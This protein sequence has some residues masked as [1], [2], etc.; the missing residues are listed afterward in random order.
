MLVTLINSIS[1]I[2][3]A[4]FG[5]LL[6]DR[7][8][9]TFKTVVMTAAGLVTF[10]M[11]IDM[12]NTEL[13][14]ISILFAFILGGFLGFWIRIDERVENFGNKFRKDESDASFGYGFLSSSILFCSGAM[15]IVGSINVGTTGDGSLILIKSVMDGFMAVVFAAAYGKGVFLSSISVLIYQGFFVLSA[16]FISPILGEDG[17]GYISAVGGYLLVMISLGLLNI[18]Q[19][20]TANFLPAIILAPVLGRVLTFL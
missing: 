14:V 19:I 5:I 16:S 2:I 13:S 4:F 10:V 8:S 9:D 7:I 3:G 17:I 15:S 20:K 6:K 18:K 1:V 12:A 11:G